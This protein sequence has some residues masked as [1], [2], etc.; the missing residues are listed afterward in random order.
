MKSKAARIT[1]AQC[2]DPRTG[3]DQIVA[4]AM[5]HYY[6]PVWVA[7]MTNK[8]NEVFYHDEVCENYKARHLEFV[9]QNNFGI[10]DIDMEGVA[11][12][13]LV[14]KAET[15]GCRLVKDSDSSEIILAHV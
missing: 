5:R 11:T 15:E 13:K 12:C 9:Q 7:K 2:N 6:P 4:S 10:I 14:T 8:L 1:Q 3:F